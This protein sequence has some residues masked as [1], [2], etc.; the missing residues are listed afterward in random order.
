MYRNC[1][2]TI[3]LKKTQP[4][5]NGS[6]KRRQVISPFSLLGIV[7]HE[8]LEEEMKKHVGKRF[9]SEFRIDNSTL[10]SILDK[11]LS[12]ALPLVD[13]T[14]IEDKDRLIEWVKKSSKKNLRNAKSLLNANA[15]DYTVLEVEQVWKHKLRA[16]SDLIVLA[17]LVLQSPNNEIY[18]VDWK[19]Q[20][21]PKSDINDP[22]LA[23]YKLLAEKKYQNEQ[24]KTVI[25]YTE[26][27]HWAKPWYSPKFTSELENNIDE[28][29]ERW[30]SN[31]IED[32]PANPHPV[33]C[34]SCRYLTRCD[35]AYVSEEVY[36]V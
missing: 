29:I 4:S 21:D 13:W 25:A 11:K 17:D 22:Q 18:V 10:F 14:V 34:S 7:V 3:W 31:N 12:E 24:I 2:R 35:V 6:G 16:E 20:K 5:S 27:V 30:K 33:N 36:F 9:F 28:E 1:N 32:F 26:R 15:R 8:T 19:T 23:V